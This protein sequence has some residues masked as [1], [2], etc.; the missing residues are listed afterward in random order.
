VF[1]L[2]GECTTDAECDD[3]NAHTGEACGPTPQAPSVPAGACSSWWID[4]CS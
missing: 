4:P 1:E 2:C 3:G